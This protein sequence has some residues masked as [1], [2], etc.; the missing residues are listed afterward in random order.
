MNE[1]PF[2]ATY[3]LTAYSFNQ[4]IYT[5]HVF[6]NGI[7]L[8]SVGNVKSFKIWSLLLR[9]LQPRFGKHDLDQNDKD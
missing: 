4:Q 6:F 5:D 7:V 8:G 1:R 2:F 3:K 9:N